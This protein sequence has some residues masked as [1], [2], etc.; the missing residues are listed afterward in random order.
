MVVLV[1]N[2]SDLKDKR[3]VSYEEGQEKG[4]E[5]DVLFFETS[6]KLC[7][8]IPEIMELLCYSFSGITSKQSRRAKVFEQ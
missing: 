4:R 8:N 7:T 2:K 5:L 3:V 1:G 6:A